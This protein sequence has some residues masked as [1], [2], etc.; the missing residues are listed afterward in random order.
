MVQVIGKGWNRLRCQQLLK[1]QE[2]GSQLEVHLHAGKVVNVRDPGG[3]V[4]GI[5]PGP[6]DT[7]V[8]VVVPPDAVPVAAVV[9]QIVAEMCPFLLVTAAATN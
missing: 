6:G 8:V 4:V 9:A 1:G 3:E 5:E 7:P 2:E